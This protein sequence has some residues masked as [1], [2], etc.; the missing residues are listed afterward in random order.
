MNNA[1]INEK[2]KNIG[3]KNS[4][5]S[6]LI[7]RSSLKTQIIE[8]EVNMDEKENEFNFEEFLTPK[9]GSKN[10]IKEQSEIIYNMIHENKINEAAALIREIK[11]FDFSNINYETKIEIDKVFNYLIDHLSNTLIVI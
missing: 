8:S 6:S 11:N 7:K 3:R 4:L 1:K 5:K 10:W 9:K 2:I